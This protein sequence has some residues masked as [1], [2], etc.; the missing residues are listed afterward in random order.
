[1]TSIITEAEIA[2]LADRLQA[3]AS[4]ILSTDQRSARDDLQLAALVLQAILRDGTVHGFLRI[5][6]D[7]GTP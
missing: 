7:G 3:R 5:A 4:S 2:A 6:G 1:M